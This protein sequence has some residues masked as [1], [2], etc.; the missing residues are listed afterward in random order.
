MIK[1]I[2]KGVYD[3]SVD[4]GETFIHTQN[5]LILD[6]YYAKTEFTEDI[7]LA[8]G[9]GNTPP[10]LSD[11]SLEQQIATSLTYSGFEPSS[12]KTVFSDRFEISFSR[13]FDLGVGHTG[14]IRELGVKNPDLCSR[15]LLTAP[16][17]NP[18]E[19]Q[20]LNTDHIIV[21]YSI[22]YIVPRTPQ[23]FPLTINGSPV[24]ATITAVNGEN[25]GWGKE[26]LG[27]VI[28]FDYIG[29]SISGSWSIDANGNIVGGN[30]NNRV[31]LVTNVNGISGLTIVGTVL[32][33]TDEWVGSFQQL[34]ITST[35]DNYITAPL[36]I[37]FDVPIVKAS[38]EVINISFSINQ[39]V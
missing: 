6:N 3:I 29:S 20:L 22:V 32:V 35:L 1:T 26:F 4:G 12:E 37:E 7:S 23:T 38:T 11:D 8:I 10:E 27:E 36:L 16:D 13:L 30:T 34:L 17:G 31:K 39:D 18:T 24:N 14:T 19:V 25:G 21:R 15:A 28:R 5:N 33:D 2:A 9:S